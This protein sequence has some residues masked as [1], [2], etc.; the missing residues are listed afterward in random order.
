MGDQESFAAW[1]DCYA[2]VAEAKTTAA[3]STLGYVVQQLAPQGDSGLIDRAPALASASTANE[4]GPFIFAGGGAPFHLYVFEG[5]EGVG[6]GLFPSKAP[7]LGRSSHSESKFRY[8]W[9][10]AVIMLVCG[11]AFLL[12]AYAAYWQGADASPAI[13][14]SDSLTNRL[15][16]AVEDAEPRLAE[17]AGL[18]A[19]QIVDD[20]KL[21]P[22]GRQAWWQGAVGNSDATQGGATLLQLDGLA[23]AAKNAAEKRTLAAPALAG[24]NEADRTTAARRVADAVDRT[25]RYDPVAV[26][27]AVNLAGWWFAAIGT[28][29]ILARV[30]GKGFWGSALGVLIDSRNRLSLSRMQLV[31]WSILVLSLFAVTSTF[32]IGAAGSQAGLPQYPWEIWALLGISI[33]TTPLSGLILVTKSTQPPQPNAERDIMADPSATNVGRVEVKLAENGWSFL[34]FFRGEEIANRNEID[35]SRFQYFVI[36]FV[37][38]IVFVA[39]TGSELWAI[40][41]GQ[42]W[43]VWA[44]TKSYPHLNETFIALLALSHGSYLGMKMLAKPDVTPV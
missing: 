18:I 31:F 13:F 27:Q 29:M 11:A 23:I 21:L 30:I 35:V 39:L 15:Q 2:A 38:M 7:T 10:A 25:F 32:L 19:S 12:I 44:K 26:P 20:A 17:D 36:T 37:L 33:G 14:S 40:Q 9:L 5:V 4:F 6:P 16:A 3:A 41:L 28:L 43:L 22:T 8:A 42:D 24:V 34:D 1:Q